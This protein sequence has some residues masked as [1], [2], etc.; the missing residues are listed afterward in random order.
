[1]VESQ[2]SSSL[3]D[4]G[5]LCELGTATGFEGTWLVPRL[6][7]LMSTGVAELVEL[8]AVVAADEAAEKS[9]EPPGPSGRVWSGVDRLVVL[10][11]GWTAVP[12]A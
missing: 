5:E 6:P 2:L 4:D 10:D 8:A 7:G 3:G 1:V 9:D 12:C 11:G